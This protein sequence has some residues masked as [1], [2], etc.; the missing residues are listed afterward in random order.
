M[1]CFL[2]FLSIESIVRPRFFSLA[3]F[4]FLSSCT[5]AVMSSSVSF[6]LLDYISVCVEFRLLM[7]VTKADD[8]DRKQRRVKIS[9]SLFSPIPEID[10]Y[11]ISGS[12]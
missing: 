7:P 12:E 10:C 9:M 3:F 6:C 1:T 11:T 4:F 5:T 2:L 8:V